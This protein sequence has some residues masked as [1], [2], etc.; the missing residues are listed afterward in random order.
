M[1]DA[2]V[3]MV[4]AEILSSENLSFEQHFIFL[5]YP[6]KVYVHMT[7]AKSQSWYFKNETQSLCL[8]PLKFRVSEFHILSSLETV[9]F[10]MFESTDIFGCH[11]IMRDSTYMNILM[12]KYQK[13]T[14]LR[15]IARI[16]EESLLNCQRR[17]HLFPCGVCT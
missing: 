10:T 13:N 15:D 3:R 17:K 8:L 1:F 12:L 2:K 14:S 9:E 16:A 4:S 6:G 11:Q 5:E 7:Q